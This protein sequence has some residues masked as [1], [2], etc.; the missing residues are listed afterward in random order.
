MN[1]NQPESGLL[2]REQYENIVKESKSCDE[3]LSRTTDLKE[4]NKINRLPKLLT[5]HLHASVR[6]SWTDLIKYQ[7]YLVAIHQ[8][9]MMKSSI[10]VVIIISIL[11]WMLKKTNRAII[12]D[13]MIK[14]F[15]RSQTAAFS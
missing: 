10:R 8:L 5:D 14:M 13:F 6:N 4:W 7:K 15:I 11:Y 9:I 3:V 2:T 1:P 12:L